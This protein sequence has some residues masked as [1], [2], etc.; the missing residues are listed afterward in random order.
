MLRCRLLK[1]SSPSSERAIENICLKRADVI[2]GARTRFHMQWFS[3][4]ELCRVS[5][6]WKKKERYL[7][8]ICN[9]NRL[10][11]GLLCT[12][13]YNLRYVMSA[14]L[15]CNYSHAFPW[16]QM[17]RQFCMYLY[18]CHAL[19]FTFRIEFCKNGSI[20]SFTKEYI[21]WLILCRIN[22]FYK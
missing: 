13:L 21:S 16:Y 2:H 18:F 22:E 9:W 3:T 8:G 19:S 15:W 1:K 14:R 17:I 11:L 20:F 6:K 4:N 5:F 10:N 7:I 12:F